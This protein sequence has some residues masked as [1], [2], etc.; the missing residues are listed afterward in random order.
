MPTPS[1]SSSARWRSSEKALGPDHP[2]VAQSLNNLALLYVNQGRYA[3]AE[4]LYKRSL[5]INEKALGPDHPDVA[6]SLNNLAVLYANQG[7]YAD[8][9]PLYKRSLAIREKALGPDHPDVAVSLNNLAALY[10]DQGRYAGRATN[11]SPHHRSA[12]RQVHTPHSSILIG[13][14]RANL[15]SEAQSFADSYKRASI[16]VVFCRRGGSAEGCATLR[17]RV[18]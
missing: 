7:R 14:Q 1:R 13:S 8:A 5:A 11:C 15:I 17:C 10:D 12:Q 16:L 18:G 9:E 6:T 2:D 4:P 3:D